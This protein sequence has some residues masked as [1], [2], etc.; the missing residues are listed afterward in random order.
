[1][2]LKNIMV[3]VCI[4]GAV[5]IPFQMYSKNVWRSVNQD[6]LVCWHLLLASETNKQNSPVTFMMESNR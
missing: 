6:L 3:G 5:P 1:M 4:V 2:K